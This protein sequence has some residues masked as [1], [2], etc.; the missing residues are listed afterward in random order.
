M[1]GETPTVSHL[2]DV[3]TTDQGD[4]TDTTGENGV[5]SSSS[6][7]GGALYFEYRYFVVTIGIIGTV[8]NGI[9]LYAMVASKQHKKHELIFNQNAIDLYTCVFLVIT[10]GL[11]L[12]DINLSGTL[13]Y[14]LCMFLFSEGLLS[15]GLYASY[16]NLIFISIERYLKVVH[17]VWSKKKL[18]K[19][20]TY[21]AIA[22]AWVSGFTAE[23]PVAFQTSAVMDGVCFGYVVYESDETRLGLCIHYFLFTYFVVLLVF[24]FCYGKILMVIR[25][26][27]RTMAGYNHGGSVD[28][29]ATMTVDRQF[30]IMVDRKATIPVNWQATIPVD[31]TPLR[32]SHIRFRPT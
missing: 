23:I 3:M 4:I 18:R 29:Q 8:A 31:Q 11:K 12:F 5:T 24:A 1:S 7:D 15:C 22:C 6:R 9:I 25:R 2:F 21:A 19:W 26:Q 27:A 17:S 16:I 14:W 28:R 32:P 30:T 10:Y 13:G 20:M